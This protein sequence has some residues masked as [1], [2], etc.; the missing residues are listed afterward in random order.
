MTVRERRTNWVALTGDAVREP[1]FS[2]SSGGEDYFVFPLRC[3]RLSGAEDVLQVVVSR[4]LLERRDIRAGERL[5]LRGTVR[6]WNNRTGTGNRLVITV[7]AARLLQEHG[8]EDGNQVR[9]MGNLC[10]E[11]VYRHTPLGREIAD[12]LLAVNGRGSRA[13]Y[14]PCIA[15]GALARQAARW[16][17]GDRVRL[18]GRLQ[19]RAYMKTMG[20]E[21]VEKVAYEV[22]AMAMERLPRAGET[23]EP[24]R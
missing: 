1:A 20:E 7:R 21:R 19:S 14:L 15:W 10:K 13:D 16:Q 18:W 9:L 8:T 24:G 17:V 5:S 2:H 3:R 22:S 4:S 23:R 12:L 6:S 11:P